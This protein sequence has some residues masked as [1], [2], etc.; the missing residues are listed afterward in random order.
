MND[1]I[2]HHNLVHTEKGMLV[3][4]LHVSF[5]DFLAGAAGMV[6]ILLSQTSG[7]Y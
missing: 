1:Q 7:L 2:K 4:K 5:Q 3:A 6:S